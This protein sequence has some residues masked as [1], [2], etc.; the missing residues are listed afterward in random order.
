MGRLYL[1]V[2][3]CLA[4]FGFTAN[5]MTALASLQQSPNDPV[6]LANLSTA[7]NSSFNDLKAP[8]SI[9][10]SGNDVVLDRRDDG[11][12]YANVEVNGTP[13]EMMVD[14][15]ASG[16]ALSRQDARRAGIATSI[17]M[18]DYVGDGASGVV[19]GD[20]VTIERLRFG[21]VEMTGVPGAVLKGGEI[22]LLG[23]EV[24]RQF[25]KV[26]IEGDRMVLR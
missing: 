9:Q 11:H 19:Y 23:Q 12:F 22:S 2:L 4:V 16:V 20:D 18:T 10:P 21:K 25:D 1:L 15:G 5:R 6:R 8:P 7:P 26:E 17:G 24:L 3:L 13:I 14:T